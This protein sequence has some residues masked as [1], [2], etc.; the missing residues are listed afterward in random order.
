MKRKSRNSQST[1]KRLKSSQGTTS[2]RE[3]PEFSGVA[4]P[5]NQADPEIS[6]LEALPPELRRH[7]LSALNLEE[8]QSLVHASPVYY[9]QYV[10]DR[11]WIF[12]C[13]LEATFPGAAAEACEVYRTSSKE[14]FD[15][16]DE[17]K[18]EDVIED[19]MEKREQG[20]FSISE[21]GFEMDDLI[22]MASFHRNTVM[23]L[24]REYAKWAL[25]NLAAEKESSSDGTS[26][27][28]S[29]VEEARITRAFYRFQLLCNLL[30][31]CPDDR[32][33]SMQSIVRFRDDDILEILHDLWEPWECE[34]VLCVQTFGEV[35]YRRILRQVERHIKVEEVDEDLSYLSLPLGKSKVLP[36]S[37]GMQA[38]LL[39]TDEDDMEEFV[40]ST[41]SRGLEH[42]HTAAFL[43]KSHAELIREMQ[44]TMRKDLAHSFLGWWAHWDEAH[45]KRRINA[46]SAKDAREITRETFKFQGD[47]TIDPDGIYPPLAWT[48]LWDET[49]SNVYGAIVHGI[50]PESG[51]GHWGWVMWDAERVKRSCARAV[52][53]R[54]KGPDWGNQDPRDSMESAPSPRRQSFK[55]NSRSEEL[56]SDAM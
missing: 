25:G 28:L 26:E 14:W 42:L 12:A 48:I 43:I 23:P 33:P 55:P 35:Q 8:L 27:T 49:Y 47:K 6:R 11:K 39:P 51:L 40:I 45:W 53:E 32:P 1:K 13:S 50:R 9:Q 17:D 5:T 37:F 20:D 56:I 29:R 38:N 30:G 36:F 7:L 2:Q 4:Q 16:R 41:L 21:Q 22:R 24:V 46:P 44:K 54:F 34:E 3:I 10:L 52:I 18:V 19:L 31:I 15:E